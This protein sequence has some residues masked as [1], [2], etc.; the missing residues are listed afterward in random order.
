[1][2][3]IALTLAVVALTVSLAWA[4]VGEPER[5]PAPRAPEAPGGIPGMPGGIPPGVGRR[6][7]GPGGPPGMGPGMPGMG[8]A[9]REEWE[10]PEIRDLLGAMGRRFRG[11]IYELEEKVFAFLRDFAADRV[12][13]LE[14]LKH[15][16]RR[17]YL[18]ALGEAARFMFEAEEVKR[19]D[20]EQYELMR[21]EIEKQL[22]PLRSDGLHHGRLGILATN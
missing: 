16:N 8:V 10:D 13:G 17:E 9:P 18:R 4:Q 2:R 15:E 14:E 22:P 20:P 19:H 5:P 1:M 7:M 6:G 12:M 3:V 11:D 21:A